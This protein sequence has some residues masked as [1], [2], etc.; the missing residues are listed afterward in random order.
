MEFL[1]TYK[2]LA[3]ALAALLHP[4][5][6]V[7]VHDLATQQVAYMANPF[8][9]REIGAPS[10]IDDVDFTSGQRV[11]GPYQKLNWD[12]RMLKSISVV[13]PDAKGTPEALVCINL[14][15]SEMSRL[16]QLLG[17]MLALPET[18]DPAV[19]GLFRDDWHERI[20][21]SIQTWLRDEGLT[22][23]SL[24]R[25]DKRRLVTHLQGQGA[26]QGQGAAPY[27]A[28]CLGLARATIYKY[29]KEG[30]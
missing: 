24:S 19:D 20:N 3:D 21:Q 26:F 8:S 10:L 22:L 14:D 17:T 9:N 25:E 4:H 18:P 11:I 15:Q 7:V 30:S 27:V 28:Q 2:N 23:Q 29:L 6:E 5:A 16:H 12:G 13:M 1:S